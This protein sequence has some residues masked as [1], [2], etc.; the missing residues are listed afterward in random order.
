MKQLERLIINPTDVM[1]ITGFT[2]RRACRLLVKIKKANKKHGNALVTID[3][4]CLYTALKKE[5]V[6]PYL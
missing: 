6:Q 5:Q 4:F 3:E 2:E 1:L